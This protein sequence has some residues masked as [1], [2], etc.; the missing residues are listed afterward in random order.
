MEVV[1]LYKVRLMGALKACGTP[2]RLTSSGVTIPPINVKPLRC[3]PGPIRIA[4]RLRALERR[5]VNIQH[6]TRLSAF[7]EQNSRHLVENALRRRLAICFV[8][9]P[10]TICMSAPPH[11]SQPSGVPAH[12]SVWVYHLVHEFAH[13]L[14]QPVMALR[15]ANAVVSTRS[16]HSTARQ[17]NTPNAPPCSTGSCT[18]QRATSAR[19]RE[20]C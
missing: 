3:F 1:K 18:P 16:A 2:G 15:P 7:G 10:G 11:T 13:R 14:L 17:T 4:W 19:H 20:P 9:L 5:A 12:L 8:F 6:H